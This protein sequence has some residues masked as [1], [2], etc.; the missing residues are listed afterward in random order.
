MPSA[1]ARR[2]YALPL[3]ALGAAGAAAAWLLLALALDQQCAWLAPLVALDMVL[4]LRLAHWRAGWIRAGWA[5]LATVMVIAAANVLIAAGQ[6]GA[7][8]GLHTLES[9]R[10]IGPHYA[11]LLIGLAN[12]PIDL[13]LYGVGLLVAVVSGLSGRRPAPSAR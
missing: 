6:I 4:L 2:W 12:R 11:W 8:L 9:V 1:P 13:L 3:L 10:L 5:L 7:S